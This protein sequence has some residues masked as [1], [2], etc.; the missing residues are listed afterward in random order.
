MQQGLYTKCVKRGI[1]LYHSHFEN[2]NKSYSPCQPVS[3][4]TTTY[5]VSGFICY[6]IYTSQ[7]C[8]FNLSITVLAIK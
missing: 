8:E 7:I 4:P 1:T 5:N 3:V 2:N 6:M